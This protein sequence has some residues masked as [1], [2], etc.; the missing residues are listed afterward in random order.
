MIF[1]LFLFIDVFFRSFWKTVSSIIKSD[2]SVVEN[3]GDKEG[4]RKGTERRFP[5]L[6][7]CLLQ[8]QYLQTKYK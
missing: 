7:D 4:K 5:C 3:K 2:K 8:F 1:F 6:I